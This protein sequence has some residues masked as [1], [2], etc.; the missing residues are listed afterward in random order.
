MHD[1][2]FNRPAPAQ[3]ALG[4]CLHLVHL[5]LHPVALPLH[6]RQRVAASSSSDTSEDEAVAVE[7]CA[8]VI[9]TCAGADTVVL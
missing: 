3:G 2:H 6:Q 7:L 5:Y 4:V 8:N 9:R 1:V